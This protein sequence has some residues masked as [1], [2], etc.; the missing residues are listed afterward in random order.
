MNMRPRKNIL[1]VGTTLTGKTTYLNELIKK[2]NEKILV[3]DINCEVKYRHLPTVNVLKLDYQK[4]KRRVVF[5]RPATVI[6]FITQDYRNGILILDDVDRYLSVT[7]IDW[8]NLIIGHRHLGLDIIF[9]FHSLRRALPIFY[10]NCTDIILF[11][12]Q[13]APDESIKKLPNADDVLKTFAIVEKNNNFHYSQR[14]RC[15]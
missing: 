1:I 12:T 2:S 9:V 11:K 10:E 5:P 3:Y 6:E 8:Q 13:E 14:I 15:R 7:S 4:G